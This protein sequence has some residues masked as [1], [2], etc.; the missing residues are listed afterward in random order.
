MKARF[1]LVGRDLDRHEKGLVTEQ[2]WYIR[3]GRRIVRAA[4]SDQIV[5]RVCRN[6]PA[7][8]V[9]NCDKSL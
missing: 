1:V 7:V 4:I 6:G 9:I 5:D 3:V 2:R 8:S